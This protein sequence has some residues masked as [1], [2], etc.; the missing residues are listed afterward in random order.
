MKAVWCQALIILCAYVAYKSTDD[1]S[2]YARDAFGYNE[3]DAA[4]I[5]TISFWMRPIAAVSAGIL[6]DRF[7]STL[8]LVISFTLVIA[9]STF[10]A[11]GLVLPGLLWLLLLT[12]AATS[13]GIY[14]LR[15]LYFAIFGQAAVPAHVTGTAV[16]V[17]SFVGFTPDVFMGPLMG[18]L[19]DNSPGAAGHQHVFAVVALFAVFGLICTM[20]FKRITTNINQ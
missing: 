6:A 2:L 18:Y 4:R 16:G 3:V 12:I 17:V 11:A 13:A 19:L 8:I 10:I 5:G 15:G 9:G 7:N 20:V 14:A 1:F